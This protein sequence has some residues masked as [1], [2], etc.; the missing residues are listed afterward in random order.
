MNTICLSSVFDRVGKQIPKGGDSMEKKDVKRILA[1][2]SIASLL[3]GAVI[4]CTP[5]Q[6]Q[7]PAPPAKETQQ[8]T[9]APTQQAPATGKETPAPSS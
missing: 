3:T 9:P 6:P 2:I 1:G 7:Q 4:G 8:E 5:Q